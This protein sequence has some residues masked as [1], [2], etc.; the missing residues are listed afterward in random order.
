ML[1]ARRK[2][3][4]ES[5]GVAAS[6]LALPAL[7]G[8][9]RAQ[10]ALAPATR[11]LAE[12]LADY[13]DR[14]RFDDLDA[15]TIER[16]KAHVIDSLGCGIAA[17]DEPPVRICR[18][19]AL[20]A[21]AGEATVLGTARR[22]SIE[23]AAFANG[24]AVRYYDLNDSYVGGLAGHP[25]DNIAACLAVAEAERASAAELVVA[26][27][28]AYEINCRMIDAFDVTA[29][30]WDSPVFSLPAVALAAGRLMKLSPEKLAQAVSL[31]LNDH[32]PMG[33]TRAQA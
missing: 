20:A 2:F 24:A 25:S 3:L 14:L 31:A 15:A 21:G 16:V 30:G 8:V 6:A 23:F 29:R 28:L 13:A 18:E 11:P 32:I 17:F 19:V 1:H 26:I 33:Q 9:A 7:H 5:L 10:A 4:R 27:V 22:T 12:R